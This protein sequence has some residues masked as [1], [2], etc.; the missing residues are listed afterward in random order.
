MSTSLITVPGYEDLK[1]LASELKRPVS[2]LIALAP[3]NDPFYAGMPSRRADGIFPRC[4]T[5]DPS[6]CRPLG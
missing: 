5:I 4:R 1:A 3:Q 6:I 2:T